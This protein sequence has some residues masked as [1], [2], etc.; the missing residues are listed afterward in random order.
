MFLKT[1]AGEAVGAR[2]LVK[3]TPVTVRSSAWKKLKVK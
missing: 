3:H 2:G 1:W